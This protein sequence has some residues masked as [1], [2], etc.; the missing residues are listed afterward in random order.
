MDSGPTHQAALDRAHAH[1]HAL[2]WLASLGHR[3]VPARA[4]IDELVDR[5]GSVLPEDGLDPAGVIDL[6]GR[7]M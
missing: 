7:R 6:L 1:A 5:R 2:T 4:S 3:P